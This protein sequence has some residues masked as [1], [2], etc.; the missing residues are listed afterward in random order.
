M[1]KRK[2]AVKLRG[3]RTHG[4]GSHK[5]HRGKGSKGGKG[6]GGVFDQKK[7]WVMKY[8][9][10]RLGKLGFKSLKGKKFKPK[11]KAI[12]IRDLNRLL[13]TVKEKEIDLGVLGYD[14]L[15]STGELK[16]PVSI[17]VH[18][19]SAAAKEKVEAAGGKILE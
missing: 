8:D 6:M 14:K 3:S 13:E 4:Y 12:N 19:Y 1:K 15:L 10:D 9:P 5:K 17:K 16:K 2:K 18:S 11:Q 7:T